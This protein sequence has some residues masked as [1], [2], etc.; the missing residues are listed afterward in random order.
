MLLKPFASFSRSSFASFI[1][2]RKNAYSSTFVIK[3]SKESSKAS[4]LGTWFDPFKQAKKDCLVV[5]T[6][7]QDSLT[8]INEQ[9][10][11]EYNVSYAYHTLYAYFGIDNIALKGLNKRGGKV[12]LRV[13]VRPLSNFDNDENGDALHAMELALALEKLTTQKPQD[14]HKVESIKKV[15]EY[16]AQLR[17]LGK[18]YGV[19]HFDQMLL[20]HGV[21]AR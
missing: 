2:A 5:P 18:G 20:N 3:A 6:C 16:V 1:G 11:V 12:K 14:L 8:P 15:V 4:T 9:I 21:A 7:P 19:W 13:I 17:K 10:N